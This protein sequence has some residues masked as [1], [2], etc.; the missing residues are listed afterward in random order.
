MKTLLIAVNALA[1]VA[2]ALA[3]TTGGSSSAT[4]SSG[5]T[6]TTGQSGTTGPTTTQVPPSSA[7]P[8]T[9]GTMGGAGDSSSSAGTGTGMGTSGTG[10]AMATT[11]ADPKAVI[12]SEFATYDKDANGSL[13]TTEFATWMSVLKEK[14]GEAPMKATEKAAW[15]KGAFTSADRDRNKQVSLTEPTTYLTAGA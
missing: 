4:G 15:L 10:T 6:G 5:T 11:P 7:D 14:S 2:P 12:A 13:D 3:Q 1:L 8:G 9:S